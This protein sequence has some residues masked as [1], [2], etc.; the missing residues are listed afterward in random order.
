MLS[1]NNRREGLAGSGSSR[2]NCQLESRQRTPH[3]VR[4]VAHANRAGAK[5]PIPIVQAR[6]LECLAECLKGTDLKF[7]ELCAQFGMPDV[8]LDR[9]DSFVPLR[10]ALMVEEEISKA[11][12]DA[13]LGLHLAE[14]S[15]LGALGTHGRYV[16]AAA[17]LG[18]AI[19]R[20]NSHVSDHILGARMWLMR[21]GPNVLW[22]YELTPSVVVGRQH[23][24]LF[25]LVLMR[26][27]VRLAIGKA[28]MPD[29][30]LL[31]GPPQRDRQDLIRAFGCPIGWNGSM[32]ALAFPRQLLARPLLHRAEAQGELNPIMDNGSSPHHP[33][34]FVDSLRRLVKSLL[35]AGPL[36][37]PLLTRLSGLPARS[38]QRELRALGLS[39][40]TLLDQGRLEL[41][42]ELMRDPNHSLIDVGME[43][44]YSDP[45]NFTRAFKRW[46]GV[47]PGVYRRV[48]LKASD[49][50][51]ATRAAAAAE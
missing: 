33:S 14:R 32:T 45:A 3:P 49:K 9:D 39:F 43:L 50:I 48:G 26:D 4:V 8:R 17:T 20:A 35:P 16:C 6:T 18:E 24:N 42:L 44:G 40:S 37:L 27:L 38:L 12:G 11:T 19:N 31:E 10:E 47:A 51:E 36:D 21:A 29:E 34:E 13:Y 15:G 30:I 23:S 5:G 7:D 22:C 46:T 41:A 25:S 1:N 28:W 2:R